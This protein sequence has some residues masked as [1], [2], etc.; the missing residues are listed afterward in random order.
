MQSAYKE[1]DIVLSSSFSEGFPNSL[2]EAAAAGKPILASDIP[3][4]RQPVLGEKGD[5]PAG[6]L[7]NPH[8]YALF[9]LALLISPGFLLPLKIEMLIKY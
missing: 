9:P 4:N 3:G 2:L 6:I 7:F 8:D 1:S 5:Q